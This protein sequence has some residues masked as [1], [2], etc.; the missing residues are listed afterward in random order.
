M[1]IRYGLFFLVFLSVDAESQRRSTVFY[2]PFDNNM[3]RWVVDSTAAQVTK[4]AAGKYLLL[5]AEKE[6]KWWLTKGIAIDPERDFDIEVMQQNLYSDDE[7]FGGLIWGGKGE[8]FFEFSIAPSGYFRILEHSS[9]QEV[10]AWKEK[11]FSALIH[12]GTDQPNKLRIEWKKD[13]YHFFIND[14]LVFTNAVN[15]IQSNGTGFLVDGQIG[16]AFDNF[17][18]S[19][20]EVDKPE[21]ELPKDARYIFQDNFSQNNNGWKL[22]ALAKIE[23]GAYKI[24]TRSDSTFF[25]AIELSI[26]SNRA[27]QI[28]ARF[29]HIEQTKT[30]GYG[31]SWSDSR[32]DY[33][34]II[35]P[36]GYFTVKR[37]NGKK[38]K[39]VKKW[40]RATALKLG[41][42]SLNKLTVNYKPPICSYHINDELVFT[43]EHEA[44]AIHEI[45]FVVGS[46]QKMAVEDVTVMSERPDD[47]STRL[48]SLQKKIIQEKEF[49]E[50][51]HRFVELIWEDHSDEVPDFAAI[52]KEDDDVDAE[53]ADIDYLT[54]FILGNDYAD[55]ERLSHSFKQDNFFVE[56]KTDKAIFVE[57]NLRTL[58]DCLIEFEYAMTV[59]QDPSVHAFFI[60]NE[61]CDQYYT[62]SIDKGSIELSYSSDETEAQLMDWKPCGKL[63]QAN[64]A[65][66]KFSVLVHQGRFYYYVNS[67]LVYQ[68]I[69]MA[70]LPARIS[71]QVSGKQKIELDYVRVY[72]LN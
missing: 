33:E 40:A 41:P 10:T 45:G 11:T 6:S 15:R 24:A 1:I 49:R 46:G 55:R 69:A 71:F 28:E 61:M 43:E 21:P 2:D 29:R 42:N 56:N 34:F 64:G 7:A 36:D 18:V 23:M 48:N 44:R 59:E 67:G 13:R 54:W 26:D 63:N 16:V 39:P 38:Y 9:P 50:T 5:H 22:N 4:I 3:K 70:F 35:S 8:R 51:D 72:S 32:N 58:P 57:S 20:E 53:E 37:F 31:L 30:N 60:E 65:M 14:T 47:L 66:N 52:L 12:P 62:L 68:G 19:V 25:S 17:K 27:F